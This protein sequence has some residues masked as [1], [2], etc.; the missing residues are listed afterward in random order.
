MPG[1]LAELRRKIW[2][3]DQTRLEKRSL[4]F[5][6]SRSRRD[7]YSADYPAA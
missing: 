2:V 5:A 4:S 6:E 1:A 3:G 7:C